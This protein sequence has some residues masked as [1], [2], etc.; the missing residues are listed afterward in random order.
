MAGN[1]T[2][3]AKSTIGRQVKAGLMIGAAILAVI[4]L[5]PDSS[6]SDSSSG[7]NGV[8]R[9]V[10]GSRSSSERS[11]SV[12]EFGAIGDGAADDTK[13]VQAAINAAQAVRGTVLFP[14]PS[15]RY[16][17]SGTL[18][19]TAP[20]LLEG[21]A[22]GQLYGG[23]Q[24]WMS[25]TKADLIDLNQGSEGTRIEG[26]TLRVNGNPTGGAG[27]AI[28]FTSSI[29][30]SGQEEVFIDHCALSNLYDGIV[31]NGGN[32]V[33]LSHLNV[34]ANMND[35]VL[36]KD[37]T[38]MYFSSSNVIGNRHANIEL[39]K[40]AAFWWTDIQTYGGPYG[41]LIDPP[42]GNGVSQIF[43][44][45]FIADTESHDAIALPATGG[46]VNQIEFANSW[47]TSTTGRSGGGHGVDL[48]NPNLDDFTWIGGWIR[49]SFLSGVNLSA[50][51]NVRFLDAKFSANGF[52]NPVGQSGIRIAP[53]VSNFAVENC[54]FGNLGHDRGNQNPGIAIAAGDSDN[55]IIIGNMHVNGTALL[56]SNQATG[57]NTVVAN[58]L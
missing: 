4:A 43:A 15:V 12:K 44:K 52:L 11:F 5:P 9:Q 30:G 31:I 45:G 21:T 13:P 50:G 3:G 37:V 33:D 35:G 32:G 17:I 51:N 39:R 41:L 18:A 46:S 20:I 14:A 16:T 10:Q 42:S 27:I 22:G 54:V 40:G 49:S 23:V 25:N 8:P 2:A 36:V 34:A 53:G 7:T 19:V 28:N 47:A 1:R 57:V 48:A 26:I 6:P 24:I 29:D 55:F 58:N 56:I 38:G